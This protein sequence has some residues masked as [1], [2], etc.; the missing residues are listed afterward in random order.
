MFFSFWQGIFLAILAAVGAIP[1]FWLYDSVQAGIVINAALIC[2]EMMF[3]SVMHIWAYPYDMYRIMAMSQAPLIH[4]V[5]R[6]TSVLAN[7]RHTLAQGDTIR[8][9]VDA[10]G[11]RVLKDKFGTS[12]RPQQQVGDM[13]NIPLDT[14]DE[15][16]DFG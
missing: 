5:Q 15:N 4:D 13:H 11:P 6:S 14:D 9:T 8:D 12:E 2:V 16:H 7:V 10:F 1:G 3:I